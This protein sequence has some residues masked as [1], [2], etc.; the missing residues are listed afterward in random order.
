MEEFTIRSCISRISLDDFTNERKNPGKT[1][2]KNDL[3]L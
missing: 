2:N 3:F 1:A